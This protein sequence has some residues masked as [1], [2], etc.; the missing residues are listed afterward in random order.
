MLDSA[1]GT[2]GS[3]HIALAC[4]TEG[5]GKPLVLLHGG[6]GSWTHWVRNIPALRTR[7]TVHALDA[8]G[9]GDSPTVSED[10]DP[11]AYVEHVR[12]AV[13][14]I[15]NNGKVG[16]VGF[17]FGGV[18]AAMLA[19]SMPESI[20]RLALLAPGGFGIVPGRRLDLRRMPEG[21]VTEAQRREVLRHNLMVMMLAQ[22]QSA[23]DAA[24]AIQQANVVRTRYDSRRFSLSAFTREALPKIAAPTMLVYGECDNLAWPS[25]EARIDICTRLKPDIRVERIPGAGHWLQYEAADDVNRLLLDF[26][27]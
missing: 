27:G 3:G 20:E 21:E 17:S 5:Q 8:P 26:F 25:I 15:A 16:L 2:E 7:F 12:A 22:P 10:L 19:A 23:D 4:H 14:G 24:I 13:R 18:V 1:R 11:A 9:C 6:M